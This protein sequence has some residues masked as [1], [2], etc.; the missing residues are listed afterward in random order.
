MA[1]FEK[2]VITGPSFY[3]F[4]T[5]FIQIIFI[6]LK[7]DGYFDILGWDGLIVMAPSHLFFVICFYDLVTL[8]SRHA[9]SLQ[10]EDDPE[11]AALLNA[12]DQLAAARALRRRE[13][14]LAVNRSL[15]FKALPWWLGPIAIS[16]KL[17]SDPDNT[18]SWFW[19][20]IPFLVLCL[21][22]ASIG[23]SM[24]IFMWNTQ[25]T[26]TEED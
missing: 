18:S 21:G 5:L 10:D 1:R 11:D 19:P 25:R 13:A 23:W 4:F 7:S 3:V 14:E 15:I 24:G 20:M 16:F 12:E 6:V 22:Y 9:R 17:G 8:E 26:A 2:V